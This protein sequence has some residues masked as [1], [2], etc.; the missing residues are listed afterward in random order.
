MCLSI[1]YL[2]ISR[3][4]SLPTVI[5]TG[6]FFLWL[7]DICIIYI[8]HFSNVNDYMINHYFNNKFWVLKKYFYI[9]MREEMYLEH[10]GKY[11][12]KMWSYIHFLNLGVFFGKWPYFLNK[13]L[14]LLNVTDI[15]CCI[16]FWCIAKWFSYTC[17]YIS[18]PFPLWFIIGNWI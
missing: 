14:L 2:C 1:H 15:Q 5:T 10:I 12:Y 16:S 13:F 17:I 7:R 18:Y 11:F 4:T 3:L 9:K 6:L 8:F